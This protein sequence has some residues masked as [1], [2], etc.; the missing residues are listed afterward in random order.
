MEN[1][2]TTACSI[3]VSPLPISTPL[4]YHAW[5]ILLPWRWSQDVSPERQ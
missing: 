1:H 3:V 4:I 5:L 2:K